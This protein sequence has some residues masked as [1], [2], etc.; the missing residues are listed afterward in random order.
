MSLRLTGSCP[1][2]P[3][4]LAAWACLASQSRTRIGSCPGSLIAS[5]GDSDSSPSLPARAGPASTPGRRRH[6]HGFKSL[7]K[8]PV[9]H[10]LGLGG[11]QKPGP[12]QGLPERSKASHLR[13]TQ[14]AARLKASHLSLTRPRKIPY[15][16]QVQVVL[17]NAAGE[18][19][20]VAMLQAGPLGFTVTVTE[21]R[22]TVGSSLLVVNLVVAD[23]NTELPNLAESK[24]LKLPVLVSLVFSLRVTI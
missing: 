8:M 5:H 1:A 9:M 4:G 23:P 3:Q 2:P 24:E 17:R 6:W 11:M 16:D 18:P 10:R 12:R 20:S 19:N 22:G 13:L 14:V 7:S 15:S 21:H